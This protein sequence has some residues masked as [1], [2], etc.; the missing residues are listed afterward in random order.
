MS[1]RAI[2][3]VIIFL[4][5]AVTTH[6][7]RTHNDHSDAISSRV[8]QRVSANAHTSAAS[9]NAPEEKAPGR[10]IAPLHFEP[11]LLLLLGSGLF[12]AGTTI[13]FVISRRAGHRG[14]P[15]RVAVGKPGGGSAA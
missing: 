5:L 3:T 15:R 8:V 7:A 4:F 6:N 1:M 2:F 11:F 9:I 14:V 12:S 10:A 13:K